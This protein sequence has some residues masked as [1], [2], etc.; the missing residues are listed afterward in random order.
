MG[1]FDR[2]VGKFH[3]LKQAALTERPLVSLHDV[4]RRRRGGAV[5]G[6][7]SA[8]LAATFKGGPELTAAVEY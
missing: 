8:A 5:G 4:Q 2:L 3:D 1:A 6:S 7:A